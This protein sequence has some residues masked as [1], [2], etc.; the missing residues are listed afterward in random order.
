MRIAVIGAGNWGINLVRNLRALGVLSH[1]AEAVADLRDRVQSAADD[2][3]LLDDYRPLLEADIDAVAIATP[4]PT[5]AVI[6]G[7]F[8]AAGKD[9]FVE[10]PMTLTTAEA[11]GLVARAEEGRRILMVGHLLLY[12]PA[13]DW[14]KEYLGA[15]ELGKVYSFHQERMKFGR[16]RAAENVLSS[17]GVHDVAVLLHLAGS[18]PVATSFSGHCG[19][20]DGIDDDTY[21]HMEFTG[22][23]KA[24]LHNSWLWPENRRR[25]TVVGEKGMLVYNELAQNVTLHRKTIDSDLQNQDGGEEVVFEG[26]GQ[27]LRLEMQHFIECVRTRATPRSDGKNGLDVLRVLDS[28]HGSG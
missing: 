5:H 13:I 7:E 2:V 25:L 12:Q 4:V 1:V 17:L 26:S 3:E 10:K 18:A 21:L 24:H 8:L 19:L 9:V 6:A 22:G 14:L 16:A 15:G 20:Q 11:E 23:V 27:A 28:V